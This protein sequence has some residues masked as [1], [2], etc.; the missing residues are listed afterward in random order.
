[1]S[2]KDNVRFPAGLQNRKG[3]QTLFEWRRSQEPHLHQI[4]PTNHCPY[5]CV[6]CPRSTKMSRSLGFMEMDLY[7]KVIDEVST[8]SAPVREKEIELF[9]F[10][11]SLLHPE[12][13][14]MVSYGAQKGL[15]MVLSV[16]GP[17]L[18]PERSEALL[19]AR[20]HKIIISLDGYD[21]AS[22]RAI[23]GPVADYEKA[24]RHI[25]HLLEA[26]AGSETRIVIRMIEIAHNAAH[27]EQ[28]RSQWEGRGASVEVREFFPWTERDLVALGKV[29][30]YPPH[31]PCPFPWQY[32]VVQWDGS[33]VAC[34]RDYNSENPMGNVREESLKSI[35]NGA[36]YQAFRDAHGDGA[37]AD[38]RLCSE[39]MGIYFND[40]TEGAEP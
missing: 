19:A 14:A 33:V 37:L 22:Y 5:S 6:M 3:W 40:G 31:M 25:D 13:P 8:Y 38:K 15:K 9:H 28:F 4:E 26:A 36:R 24:V 21:D 34:C 7:R 27:T 35:W 32:L 23:R 39:C 1:M 29:T 30:R 10:G 18:T 12:L 17:H 11:E 20:A 2:I 16:N